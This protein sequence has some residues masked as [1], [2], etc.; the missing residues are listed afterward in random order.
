MLNKKDIDYFYNESFA[1]TS[2]RDKIWIQDFC[3]LI[4]KTFEPRSIID[5]GCGTGDILKPFETNGISILGIDGSKAN[6][7]YA[8]IKKRN[9]IIF[10]LRK[11]YQ[12]KKL[13]DLCFCFEVAEHIEEQYSDILI[14]NL[15]RASSIILFTAAPQ[16]QLGVNHI[17]LKPYQWWCK[18][19]VKHNFKL[20]NPLTKSIKKRMLSIP[21][22]SEWYTNNLLV[23]KKHVG[24]V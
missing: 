23:F 9:F 14:D 24:F 7:K 8:K 12:L 6:K 1:Q 3:D 5:F 19:F 17:N 13:Y 16:G 4:L 20:C 22:M 15:A 2:L 11:C 18:K 10:D 21:N